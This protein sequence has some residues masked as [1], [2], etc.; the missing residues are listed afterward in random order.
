MVTSNNSNDFYLDELDEEKVL[1]C[2]TN[3]ENR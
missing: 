1:Y 3:Q 2:S